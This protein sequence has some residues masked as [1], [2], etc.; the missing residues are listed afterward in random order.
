MK[1]Q[2]FLV[3]SA[4]AAG[5]LTTLQNMASLLGSSGTWTTAAEVDATMPKSGSS[6]AALLSQAVKPHPKMALAGVSAGLNGFGTGVSKQELPLDGA[7]TRLSLRD[8]ERLCG[9]TV[10]GA[11]AEEAKSAEALRHRC[12]SAVGLKQGD[13]A[14][15]TEVLCQKM[16]DELANVTKAMVTVENVALFGSCLEVAPRLGAVPQG[17]KGS[18]EVQLEESTLM[19]MCTKT[20]AQSLK[21]LRSMEQALQLAGRVA[22]VCMEHGRSIA[23]QDVFTAEAVRRVCH[24]LDGHLSEAIVGGFSG[25]DPT[26]RHES[27]RQFCQRFVKTAQED[28]QPLAAMQPLA[29]VI[30]AIAVT[31]APPAEPT[32][33]PGEPSVDPVLLGVAHSSALVSACSVLTTHLAS[34]AM[35]T[36]KGKRSHSLFFSDHDQEQLAGCTKKVKALALAEFLRTTK[37]GT[38]LNL[39]AQTTKT[40]TDEQAVADKVSAMVISEIDAP[41][42]SGICADMAISFLDTSSKDSHQF[43]SDYGLRMVGTPTTPAPRKRE[44]EHMATVEVKHVVKAVAKHEVKKPAPGAALWRIK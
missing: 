39:L 15:E 40:S 44:P 24:R 32:V 28:A 18:P 17:D 31:P 4:L 38:S 5:E 42:T 16:S 43:C 36:T 37:E 22:P 8:R 6:M 26:S 30:A 23:E 19:N 34:T 12:L 14:A 35:D 11:S 2:T 7:F 41:W 29:E 3:L 10:K 25:K 21:G 9:D 20:S 13:A 33:P 27:R 1:L